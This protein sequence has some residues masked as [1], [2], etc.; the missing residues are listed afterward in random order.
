[1]LADIQELTIEQVE[2]CRRTHEYAQNADDS[3]WC[4]SRK[5]TRCLSRIE[6]KHAS[7]SRGGP[8]GKRQLV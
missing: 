4:I 5:E 8:F 7:A 6:S 3:A 1:M 2:L